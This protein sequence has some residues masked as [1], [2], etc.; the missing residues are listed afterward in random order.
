MKKLLFVVLSLVLLI[1]AF[2]G[3]RS[4]G[5]SFARGEKEAQ[6]TYLN[7]MNAAGAYLIQADVADA[8]KNKKDS[9]ALCLVNV[10]A[11]A[12]VNAVR[13]C[14]ENLHCRQEAAPQLEKLA[15]ELLGRGELRIKYYKEQELCIPE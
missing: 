15:P 7:A 2:L 3:G 11:S 13:A 6:A 10:Q 12:H 4:A 8:L 14:L 9:R 1:G 5:I